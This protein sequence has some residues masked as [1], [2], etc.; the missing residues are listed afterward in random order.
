[1]PDYD[2]FDISS[3]E[4][5]RK[6]ELMADALSAFF[7]YHD[8][9]GDLSGAEID[10]IYRSAY[11]VGDCQIMDEG[12]HGTPDERRCASMWGAELAASSDASVID[13]LELMSRFNLWYDD[14]DYH[15][16]TIDAS[17]ASTS[18]QAVAATLIMAGT[19]ATWLSL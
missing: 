9:G 14:L 4:D 17:S 6:K 12:H 19:A 11:S 8:S 10:R 18:S 15:C 3:E 5:S 16:A 2:G 1:M 7:L 13:L